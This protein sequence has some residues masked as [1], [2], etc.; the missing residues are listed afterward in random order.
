MGANV[1]NLL[2]QQGAAQA[3]GALGRAA[4]FVQMAQ[5]PGQLAGY[6]LATGRNVFGNLFGGASPALTPVEPG[7]SGLPSYAVMPPPGG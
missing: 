2:G 7:I 6:Q 4:P 3:G 5:L 1:S